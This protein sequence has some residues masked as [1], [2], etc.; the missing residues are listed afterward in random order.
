MERRIQLVVGFLLL[1]TL[2]ALAVPLA[3]TLADRRTTRLAA[4]RDRQMAALA[5]AAAADVPLAAGVERYHELY[6][7][8]VLVVDADGRELA[9]AGDL[10]PGSLEVGRAVRLGLVGDRGPAIDRVLPWTTD[11]PLLGV[12]GREDGEIVAFAL[13]RV[14]TS[15]AAADVR[16]DW[17]LIVAGG[18]ALLVLAAAL[19]RR[20]SRWTMRPVHSLEEAARTVAHGD[21][22]GDVLASGPAELRVLVTEFNRMVSA[23]DLSLEQQRRL[24]ADASHQL[25]NP[26]A[27]VRLRADGLEPHLEP[28][29]R[30]SYAALTGELDRLQRLLDQLLSLARAQESAGATLA[31][32]R[33]DDTTQPV[34][35]VV[36]ERVE[37]WR[38]AA[39]AA[40]QHLVVG[41]LPDDDVSAV[42]DQVLDVLL[43][44][45]VRYAGAGATIEVTATVHDTATGSEVRGVVRDDGPGLA[46]GEWSRATERFWRAGDQV[47]GSGLGLAIAEELTAAHGGHVRLRPATPTGTLAEFSLRV[48]S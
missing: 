6:G 42:L 18:V 29:G 28:A 40:G 36:L 11:D 19:T 15:A 3:A 41:D 27:A 47:P 5:D 8:A 39:E 13:T 17:A 38:P 25:R 21:R 33:G 44:N 35:D 16:R 10:D 4:E 7:E 26:L 24:V 43:D 37:A 1:A 22:G 14:D 34:A 2:V 12:I 48:E 31:G 32:T 46:E 20:L 30:R 23:V 45:A 9:R